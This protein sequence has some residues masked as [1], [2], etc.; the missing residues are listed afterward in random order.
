MFQVWDDQ[1]VWNVDY[2][3]ILK[4]LTVEDM[5]V[6]IT[7]LLCS[8]SPAYLLLIPSNCASTVMNIRVVDP[9]W[10]NADPDPVPNP[11]FWWSNIENFE[12]KKPGLYKGRTSYRE[13]LKK[14]IQHFK[15]WKF[16]TFFYICRSFLPSWIRIRIQQ[17]KSMRIRIHNPELNILIPHRIRNSWLRICESR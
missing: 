4:D 6:F 13:A 2:C 16:F 11:G 1:A 8:F 5:W 9:H 10:F 12:L 7:I 17:L 14:N 15:T 3:Q